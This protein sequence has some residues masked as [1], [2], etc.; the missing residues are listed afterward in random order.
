[1]MVSAPVRVGRTRR[2]GNPIL[3]ATSEGQTWTSANT[4]QPGTGS[5][6]CSCPRPKLGCGTVVSQ[7]QQGNLPGDVSS[8]IGRRREMANVTRAL[9]AARLVTLTGT[10]GVGKTRL[11]LSAARRVQRGFSDGVFLVELAVLR[12]RTLLDRTVADTVGVRDQ[13]GRT[14]LEALA[15]HLRDK[16]MLLVLDNCEHLGHGCAVLATELLAAA[17][18]LRILATSRHALRVPDKHLL[19]LP[20]LPLPD[21]HG[22]MPYE[23]QSEAI[24]LFVDRVNARFSWRRELKRL[25]CQLCGLRRQEQTTD[26]LGGLL[27]EIR[28]VGRVLVEGERHR[29]APRRGSRRSA[30]GTW[31]RGWEVDLREGSG[32]LEVYE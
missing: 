23:R 2:A 29:S 20:P 4:R 11:A 31:R 27:V 8:F 13:S 14:P 28:D 5:M 6:R 3:T 1:M 17:P 30:W 21:P 9:F 16:Q 22:S 32:V 24:R 12:D 25:L 18:G 19:G 26:R 15:R 10:G 7:R